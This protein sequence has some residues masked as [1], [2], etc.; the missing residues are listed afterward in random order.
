MAKEERMV[1]LTIDGVQ[2]S[3]PS[4][5]TIVDAAAK[6]GIKIPTL[7]NNKRLM[8]Y[9]ACRIC[10]V[11]QKGRKNLTPACF[12]PVRNGME[13]LTRT[14][15]VVKARRTQLQLMLIS[16]PL[17]CPVCDAGGECQLQDLVYEYGV[18]DNPYPGE[19]ADLPTDHVSP[20]V[21]RNLNRCIVCGMC[22]RI[23][24]E[25][26][27]ANEISFVNRGIRT[28]IGTDF[29]RPMNCEFCGQCVS[30]CPV[31][32]LN[33]RIFLHK[34]R[35]WDIQETVTT[36]G[37]CG[38]GCTLVPGVKKDRILRV[39]GD[40]DLGVNQGN[41]C[42]KGRFGWEYVHSPGRLKSPQIRKNGTLVEAS[43]EE[44][45]G[46][47]ARRMQEIKAQTG[48]DSLA[49]LASSRLTNE[50]LYL[51]QKLLRGVLGTAHVDHSG[52]YSYTAHL[53]VRD[54][55]GYAA[56][57]NSI[58][59][60]RNAE[61]I[62]ALRSDLSE[63]HPVIKSEVVL[64]VK[65]RKSKLIVVNSR[66]IY[67]NK[68]SALGLQVKP[69]SEVALVNGMA[70]V[71]LRE[72]LA[73]EE[74]I[75]TRT[76]GIEALKAAVE[77][78]SP[79]AVEA[80][81]GI[82]A[83]KLEEAARLYGRAKKGVILISTGLNS[84]RQDPALARAAVNVALL[85]G[86]IGKESCGI[87]VLGEKNNA[88]GALDMGVTPG[89]LP[90]YAIIEDTAER[91]RFEKTWGLSLPEGRGMGA[92]AVLEGIE[93]GK[94]KALYLAGENPLATYPDPGR[95][96]KAL[97]SLD[98]LVIQDCFLTETASIAH[99]VLPA[100]AFAEKEGTYTNVDRRVQRVRPAVPAPGQAK[101]DLWIFQAL[102]TE[103][104][105]KLGGASAQA[106]NEEIR[107]LVPLYGGISYA[108][109][110]SPAT[111]AGL[112]WPCPSTDHPGTPVLYSDG[113]P[114]G[115]G[116]L[117]PAGYEEIGGEAEPAFTLIT[118]P[119]KFDSG[120]LAAR[121]PGLARLQGETVVLVH[122]ADARALG[123]AKDQRVHLESGNG[124]ISA[125][126]SLSTLTAPGV[127]FIPGHIGENGGNQLTRWDL[128][129][130]RVKLEKA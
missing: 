91:S 105:A 10:V 41:L 130:T 33:D 92:M 85:T 65:R 3:V 36:C 107:A 60:I 73:D 95:V 104:G 78:F 47:A 106:V 49:G 59:E 42:V 71:I 46:V 35:P 76:D 121:S 43:W 62:I 109:L 75:R 30:V 102:A 117:L 6:A 58:Q 120:S 66:N 50:E 99:V 26:V 51:F 82:A 13:I 12:T 24:D 72:G 52:G 74:F 122:P 40:E 70:R 98:L 81:T 22:V 25:V 21:E 67:L 54:S 100:A 126:V 57:T 113:F 83:A 61:V 17:E 20:F 94:I 110:D 96:K 9:G 19:K 37:Y 118:G 84:G 115:K 28:K 38:V 48:A 56:S 15:E 77:P 119:T 101:S 55:L 29:E 63:T 114:G 45:L 123:L 16:H 69:G 27:G 97:S 53:A 93:G 128:G 44:A 68:F 116:K 111:P 64:A 18:A 79:E 39:R 1:T 89:F 31:G 14:P 4:G 108:R 87:F 125:K 124:K 5:T 8:P 129:I 88:Q 23:C 112:Q 34:A 11:Q 32:A 86:K 103:I 90:G 2:V 80:Q 7:C 127:L